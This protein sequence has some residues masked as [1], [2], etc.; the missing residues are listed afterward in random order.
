MRYLLAVLLLCASVVQA[1]TLGEL[2][3][4]AGDRSNHVIGY[5]LV[6]GLPGTGDQTTEIPYTTQTITNMLLHMGI[7]LPPGSF[8]QPNNDAA[9]MVT[10]SLPADARPG[11]RFNV[12]VSAMGNTTSLRGGVLLLTQLHGSNGEVY[13]QAQGSVL[14]SGASAVGGGTQQIVNNPTV[15][16]IP[17]G[18][19][20]EIAAP[21]SVTDGTV[22]L[23]LRHPSYVLAARSV[24]AIN[25]VFPGAASARGPGVIVVHAPSEVNAQVGFIS[26]LQ[27]MP[28]HAPK[29]YPTVV[30]NA[31]DGT[32]VMGQDVKISPCAVATGSLSVSVTTTPEV[33]Q[34][35]P[36]GRGQTVVTTQ[37]KAGIKSHKAHLMLMTPMA[38]L[39]DVVRT[40]NMVGATPAQLAAILQAMKAA[41][42]L[43]AHIKVI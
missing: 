43:H 7:N 25:A 1:Q 18:A 8:M 33:S 26:A 6:V 15:G 39:E 23:L 16:Q 30:I 37:T 13:A 11:Q 19:V 21:N 12:T 4:I 42:S 10:G 2:V 32:V 9:V 3:R 36:F 20:A 41:G 22:T 31:Q 28:V 29:P 14:V 17:S 38:T 5:G 27:Q 40:L 34:P 35:N 24:D